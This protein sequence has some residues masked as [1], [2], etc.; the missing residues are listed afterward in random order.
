M[1]VTVVEGFTTMELRVLAQ[2]CLW[3][4]AENLPCAHVGHELR[5]GRSPLLG[6]CL[7]GLSS[8]VLLRLHQMGI[9]ELSLLDLQ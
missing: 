4:K 9:L 7:A 8:T 2:G 6:L 3:L 1:E 5:R